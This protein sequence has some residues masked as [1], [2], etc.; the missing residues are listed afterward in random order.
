MSRT[1]KLEKV[2]EPLLS[3]YFA[4]AT[5]AGFLIGWEEGQDR[6]N[7]DK[8]WYVMI[9]KVCWRTIWWPVYIRHYF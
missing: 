1:S 9:P 2:A 5:P 6:R 3:I 7:I 4:L 8:P